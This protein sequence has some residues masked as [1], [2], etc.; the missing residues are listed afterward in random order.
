MIDFSFRLFHHLHS[1]FLMMII[2]IM[3]IEHYIYISSLFQYF[4]FDLRNKIFSSQWSFHIKKYRYIHFFTK[5]I[6]YS[7]QFAMQQVDYSS[8][9]KESG[10]D[11]PGHKILSV[12]LLKYGGLTEPLRHHA[13]IVRYQ[14]S[15]VIL[16]VP[17]HL[18]TAQKRPFTVQ[19][20]N[21]T[22]V[23][24]PFTVVYDDL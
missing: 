18:N 1:L 2:M 4:S 6:S 15:L 21:K 16:A 9:A 10:D 7:F 11:V 24:D 3:I 19:Y 17:L 13:A 22:L 5:L 23:F 8:V 20:L 14:G 12:W